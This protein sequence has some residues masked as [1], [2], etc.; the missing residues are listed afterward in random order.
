MVDGGA[1][2]GSSLGGEESHLSLRIVTQCLMASRRAL[3]TGVKR[4]LVD[5]RAR[6]WLAAVVMVVREVWRVG[7][8]GGVGEAD[9]VAGDDGDG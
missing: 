6:M 9:M 5:G 8:S 2:G 1:F 4:D 7:V 3:S